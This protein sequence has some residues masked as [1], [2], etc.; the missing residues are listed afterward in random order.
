MLIRNSGE[1]SL[2]RSQVH[3]FIGKFGAYFILD[4]MGASLSQPESGADRQPGLQG[5]SPPRPRASRQLVA[6]LAIVTVA[7]VVLVSIGLAVWSEAEAAQHP[8]CGTN[9]TG[10]PIATTLNATASRN[11]SGKDSGIAECATNPCNFYNFSVTHVPPALTL[12]SLTFLLE[13][14]EGTVYVSQ[15]GLAIISHSGVLLGSWS[16]DTR[17][18]TPS[19]ASAV[20]LDIG[21]TILVYATG[22]APADLFGFSLVAFGQGDFSGAVNLPII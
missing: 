16:F 17:A 15:V 3:Q 10:C 21:A 12:G 20:T 11:S 6:V 4:M 2:D 9:M 18:W 19:A 1:L 5:K 7:G 14:P 22:P 8:Y 13:S